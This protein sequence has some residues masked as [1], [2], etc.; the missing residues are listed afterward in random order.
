MFSGRPD[1]FSDF[2][3]IIKV[4]EEYCKI[5][6]WRDM[7]EFKSITLYK[8]VFNGPE[9]GITA[10]KTHEFKEEINYEI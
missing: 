2:N 6:E 4:F 3:W 9:R 10:I 7:K 1:V 5:T 8:I